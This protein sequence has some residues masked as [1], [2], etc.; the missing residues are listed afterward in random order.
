MRYGKSDS[1]EYAGGG[2]P[3]ILGQ[4]RL[5]SIPMSKPSFVGSERSFRRAWILVKHSS[6]WS[7]VPVTET[8]KGLLEEGWA[9]WIS[10]THWRYS[11]RS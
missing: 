5:I 8:M 9:S 4:E 3:R 10:Q 11:L 1:V 2:D 6:T 7:G